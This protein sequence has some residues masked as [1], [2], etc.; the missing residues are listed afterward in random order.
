MSDH[1]H[2]LLKSLRRNHIMCSRH[3]ICYAESPQAELPSDGTF[4]RVRLAAKS[5]S[6]SW[7]R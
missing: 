6:E 7:A 3:F 4:L 2:A 5:R 1:I